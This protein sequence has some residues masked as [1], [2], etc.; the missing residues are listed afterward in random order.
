M[1]GKKK[2]DFVGGEIGC[3]AF[4][5]KAT[6]AI[7]LLELNNDDGEVVHSFDSLSS[8]DIDHLKKIKS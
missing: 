1:D 2:K 5:E 6:L 7:V 4:K 8:L 3:M